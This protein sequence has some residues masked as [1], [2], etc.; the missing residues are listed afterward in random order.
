MK[1]KVLLASP[2]PSIGAIADFCGFGSERELRRRFSA[3]TGLTMRQWRKDHVTQKICSKTSD[4]R[5]R[6]RV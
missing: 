6:G 3:D 5:R 4:L 1:A 2:S